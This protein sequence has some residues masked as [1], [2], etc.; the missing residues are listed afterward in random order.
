MRPGTTKAPRKP[1]RQQTARTHTTT[2]RILRGDVVAS[3]GAISALR[4]KMHAGA[5]SPMLARMLV[6]S[7]FHFSC[8]PPNSTSESFSLFRDRKITSRSAAAG[9]QKT[10]SS[11][12]NGAQ[13]SGGHS[14]TRVRLQAQTSAFE[15]L[16]VELGRKVAQAHHHYVNKLCLMTACV[17]GGRGGRRG[18]GPHK[19]ASGIPSTPFAISHIR[20]GPTW[21]PDT[22]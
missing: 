9:V 18:R 20:S 3:A 5:A 1:S 13:N 16:R 6:A 21:R 14:G 7:R 15:R 17:G 12:T 8:T 10:V 4:R 19:T 22:P 2:L 11:C